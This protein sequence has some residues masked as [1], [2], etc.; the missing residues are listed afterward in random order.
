MSSIYREDIQNIPPISYKNNYNID[1]II[2]RIFPES[3]FTARKN[4]SPLNKYLK[5]YVRDNSQKICIVFTIKEES[6]YVD[7]LNRCTSGSGTILLQKVEQ[8]AREIGFFKVTLI[9][10]SEIN[11]PCEDRVSL[12]ILS[13]LTTGKSWY[14]RLGYIF[15]NQSEIDSYHDELIKMRFSVF[16]NKIHEIIENK[17]PNHL[18]KFETLL[19]DLVRQQYINFE[20]TVKEVF[21]QIKYMLK[22]GEPCHE[23]EPQLVSLIMYIN[24]SNILISKSVV[25]KTIGPDIGK[26]MKRKGPTKKRKKKQN[27]KKRTKTNKFLRGKKQ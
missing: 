23:I 7:E 21:T 18:I 13:I 22:K 19:R 15:E 16:I 17:Y 9:D 27:T 12:Q 5:I 4:K 26:G 11:T 14:N 2:Q 25:T 3:E 8:L 24:M 20:S 6:I 10:S 1:D